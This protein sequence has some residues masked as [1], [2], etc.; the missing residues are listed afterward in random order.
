MDTTDT[1]RLERRL[2]ELENYVLVLEWQISKLNSEERILVED[3][4]CLI[5]FFYVC[6]SVA[7]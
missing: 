7:V 5:Q 4:H 2:S 3:A 1:E 6:V